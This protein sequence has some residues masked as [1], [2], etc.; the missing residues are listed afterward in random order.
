[1]LVAFTGQW[2]R[3]LAL[4]R[5]ANALNAISASGFYHSTLFYDYYYNAEYGKALEM[6]RQH[7]RQE[8][9]ETVVK[10]LMTYG[11]LSDAAKSK[12]YWRKCFAQWPEFS[13]QWLRDNVYPRWNFCRRTLSYA[14]KVS[15]RRN[16]CRVSSA[17]PMMG[18]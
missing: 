8:L 11:Q 15:Q 4:V 10:C 9:P 6:I 13:V 7:P 3:G 18:C 1:M 2:E 17:L 5:K 16:S 14:L 12:E